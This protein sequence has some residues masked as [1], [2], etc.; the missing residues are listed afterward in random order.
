MAASEF[1]L[2]LYRQTGC[3]SPLYFARTARM[4]AKKAIP[5][6]NNIISQDHLDNNKRLLGLGRY[7]G[8]GRVESVALFAS[9]CNNDLDSERSVW[10]S[11]S[12]R[13]ST[14]LDG[15]NVL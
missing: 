8:F 9:V 11:S 4:A 3:M 14:A 1:K 5:S 13:G 6:S 7:L 2:M 10:T 15:R 12:S